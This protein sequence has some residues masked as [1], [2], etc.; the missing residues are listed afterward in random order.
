MAAAD[1]P[2]A[3]MLFIGNS[4]TAR[5]D[6][7]RILAELAAH[8]AQPRRLTTKMIVAGGASLRRHWNAGLAQRAIE[9][10]AW[11][12]VVLQ[13]Q[14]TLPVKNAKRYHENVRLF[15]PLI[16]THG[17]RIALYL[18][19]ARRNAPDA[20]GVLTQAVSAIAAEIGALVVPV[21]PVW[22]AALREHA[23]LALYADDG[24]HPTAAG[25]YVAACTF[26]VRL[27]AQ[28]PGSFAVSDHLKVDRATA[29]KLHAAAWKV[30]VA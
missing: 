8:A 6:L 18:N 9:E 19:W 16:E 4:Y 30:A 22:Q 20:Q 11:D 17:A 3:R 7:P 24:S 10:Q 1:S 2:Q 25:S 14:S 26:L 29:E 21:G 13:E 15:A 5:N 12:Y 23:E 27:F 28:R